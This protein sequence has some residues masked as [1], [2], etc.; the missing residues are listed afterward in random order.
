MLHPLLASLESE[1]RELAS[2]V[3]KST[4]EERSA[5]VINGNWTFPRLDRHDLAQIPNT[6]ANQIKSLGG[7]AFSEESHAAAVESF[8]ERA[9]KMRAE[10]VPNLWNAH[11]PVT[12]PAYMLT[13]DSLKEW[14]REILQADANE[15]AD[16]LKQARELKNRVR[17]VEGQLKTLDPNIEALTAMMSKI[18]QTHEVAE[19]F[20]HDLED[21]QQGQKSLK[22]LLSDMTGAHKLAGDLTLEIGGYKKQI[23]SQLEAADKAIAHC[24]SAMR[25]STSFGLAGA[26]DEQSRTLRTSVLWWIVGLIGALGFGAWYGGGQL[27]KLADA[28]QADTPPAIVWTRFIISVFSVGAPVWLAWLATKQIGQRFRL[29]EDYAYKAS[30]SKAYE[31]YR[32]E[33]IELD[34]EFQSKLFASA[35]ARLDE[36]PLRFVEAETHG[37]PWHELLASDTFKE[38]IKIAPELVGKFSDIARQKVADFK[39]DKRG[40]RNRSKEDSA[41]DA[42]EVAK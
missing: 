23:T 3:L 16:T 22:Q 29:A 9:K 30:I 37:S 20:P 4:S 10:I 39:R 12:I 15:L 8:I 34:P 6:L 42:E 11:A 41:V 25:I 27:N 2:A 7:E 17:A 13:L 32:K 18:V 33:A 14:L 38:A 40:E 35:L 21:L 31:G 26:F 5:D 24:E 19:K 28:I 1:L 36:Q